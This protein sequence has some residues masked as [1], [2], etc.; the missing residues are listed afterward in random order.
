LSG[1]LTNSLIVS[2]TSS[3]DYTVEITD[4]NNCISL[5]AVSHIDIQI[6]S[7]IPESKTVDFFVSPNP[8][9][10][11]LKIQT[12]KLEENAQAILIDI[13]GREQF[14]CN[15]SDLS[16]GMDISLL[17]SGTYYL[18]IRNSNRV[19]LLKIIKL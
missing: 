12:P 15:A 5:P 1:N 13:L 10:D 8:M 6:C 14:K 4:T 16:R 7:S 11:F 19:H 3:N 2:P 9:N 17:A 18:S